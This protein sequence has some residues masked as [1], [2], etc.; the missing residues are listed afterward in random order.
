MDGV[1]VLMVKTVMTINQIRN[2]PQYRGKTEEELEAIVYN[3]NT[4]GIAGRVQRVIEKFEKDYDLTDMTSNDMSSLEELARITILLE[5]V[6]VEIRNALDESDWKTFETINKV[7]NTLRA[8]ASRVQTDL[9]ITRRARHG[10]GAESPVDI[11]EDIKKRAKIFLQQ[12]LREIYCPICGMLIAKVWWLY[13]N[14]DQEITCTCE[15]E[16]EG[17]HTA[18]H[19]FTVKFQDFQG[20]KN[21]E[22][23]PPI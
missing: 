15:R 1:P 9:N 20:N 2:L 4:G 14:P 22:I 13:E 5:D 19:T 11:V 8:D 18:P 3:I 17:F 7:A 16:N 10:Q 23:G 21:L 12:R 6:D